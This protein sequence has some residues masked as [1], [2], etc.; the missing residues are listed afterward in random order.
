[1]SVE[2]PSRSR[3]HAEVVGKNHLGGEKVHTNG[4]ML[5]SAVS[6]AVGAA[7]AISAADVVAQAPGAGVVEEVMVTGSRIR[8]TD[9]MITPV[10][11]TALS[12]EELATFEPGGTVAEQLDVLPQ[13]YRNQTAQRGS[14]GPSA[15]GGNVL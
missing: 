7:L 11:V 3:A 10:P 6:A 5:R 9:G 4:S 13:F 15:G 12:R 8:Q 1:S 2:G 14:E